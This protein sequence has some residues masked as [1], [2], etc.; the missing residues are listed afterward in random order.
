MPWNIRVSFQLSSPEIELVAMDDEVMVGGIA[1]NR[2]S[3]S[4]YYIRHSGDKGNDN[5]WDNG[6]QGY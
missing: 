6:Q 1:A 4:E 5:C 2:L 3:E